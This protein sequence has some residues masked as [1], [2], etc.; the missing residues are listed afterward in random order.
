MPG[1]HNKTLFFKLI[2]G[3]FINILREPNRC[4]LYQRKIGGMPEIHASIV[5]KMRACKAPAYRIFPPVSRREAFIYLYRQ[6]IS[7]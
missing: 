3:D 1:K 7:T 5:L 4:F 6:T 2:N